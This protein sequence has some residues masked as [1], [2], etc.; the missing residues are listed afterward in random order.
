MRPIKLGPHAAQSCANLES[1]A[2]LNVKIG[3][4]LAIDVN[5]DKLPEA[6]M[7]HVIYMG[8]RNILMDSHTSIRRR[9]RLR[10]QDMGSRQQKARC[11]V[12]RHHSHRR[13]TRQLRCG[14]KGKPVDC[15]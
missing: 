1:N 11:S 6:V 5:V 13:R 15:A 7:D 10:V 3:K 9:C 8:L 2:M 4:G 14:S 12:Q